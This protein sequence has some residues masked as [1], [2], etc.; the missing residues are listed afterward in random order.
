MSSVSP[1]EVVAWRRELAS[2]AYQFFTT[3]ILDGLTDGFR[4]GFAYGYARY[5]SAKRNMQSDIAKPSVI[6][7]YLRAEVAAIL[8]FGPVDPGVSTV[9]ISP[10]VW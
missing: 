2:Y 1:L 10:F 8:L 6:G 5:K 9:R 3:Y 7:S 4:I